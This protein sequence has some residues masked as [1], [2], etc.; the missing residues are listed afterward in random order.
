MEGFGDH[1]KTESIKVSILS[2]RKIE[3]LVNFFKNEGRVSN[4]KEIE[5]FMNLKPS[6][7]I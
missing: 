4:Q 5:E 3:I 2:F 6:K 7:E 1:R